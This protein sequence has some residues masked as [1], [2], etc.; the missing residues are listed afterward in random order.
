MRIKQDN[1][2]HKVL[3]WVGEVCF[4]PPLSVMLVFT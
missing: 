2:W 4:L 3:G 1:T